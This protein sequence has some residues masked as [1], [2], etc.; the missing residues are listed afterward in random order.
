MTGTGMQGTSRESLAAARDT[1]DTLVRAGDSDLAGLAE[2][3]FAVLTVLDREAGL[4]RAL[5]DSARSGDDRAGLAR[6]VFGDALGSAGGDLLVWAVRARWSAPRDLADAVEL[7]AVEALVAAAQAAARLD[8]VEDELFR[9]R[10]IVAGAPDL[11]TSLADRAAPVE[12]RTAL[13]DQLLEGKVG[14]ETLRL[15]RQAVT[16]PRGRSLDTTLELFG[17]VAAERRERLVATVTAAVPLTEE[18]RGRL[19][20]VLARIYGHDVQLN[21]EVAPEL[22]G[23]LRV[24]IGDEVIEGSVLSRLQEARRRLAG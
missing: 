19:G 6:A 12:S 20:A 4:R 21:V 1:L 22:V 23:G 3:L 10:R 24:E 9:T 2:E 13:V 15:V 17:Q 5:T 14:D 7:L 18:Q 11:R 8:A 16:A